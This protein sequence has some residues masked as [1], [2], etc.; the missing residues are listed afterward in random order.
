MCKLAAIEFLQEALATG[1]V[2]LDQA[3]EIEAEYHRYLSPREQ[4]GV[5]DRFYMEV[6]NSLPGRIER[7]HLPKDEAGKYDD[8]PNVPELECFDKVRG[9]S[10]PGKC[11]RS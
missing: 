9:A 7:V 4:P 3:G 6:L 5:G 8:F 1:S 2:V 10:P 11:T